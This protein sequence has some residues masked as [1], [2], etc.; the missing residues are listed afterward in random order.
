MKKEIEKVLDQV[1]PLL[2]ADGGDVE[3]VD[4]DEKKG[5]V[6]VKLT[7]VCQSC[8]H[9]QVTLDQ[10]IGRLLKEKVKGVKKIESV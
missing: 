2:K 4:F 6:R 1:R 8:P 5:I 3:F 7:G 10:G 9:S